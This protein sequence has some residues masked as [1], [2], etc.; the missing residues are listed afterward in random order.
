MSKGRTGIGT[1]E[2]K[3]DNSIHRV[4]AL[5]AFIDE[6]IF[7]FKQH[8]SYTQQKVTQ[9]GWSQSNFKS[10]PVL[11]HEQASNENLAGPLRR[12]AVGKWR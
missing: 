11:T 8:D 7:S 6:F 2:K 3:R 1:E 4:P 12:W 5:L 10:D 9:L